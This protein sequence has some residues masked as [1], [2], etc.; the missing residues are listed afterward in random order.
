M[1]RDEPPIVDTDWIADSI[2]EECK[3]SGSCSSDQDIGTPLWPHA[4]LDA[5][6]SEAL[7]RSQ[8]QIVVGLDRAGRVRWA[9]EGFARL[10]GVS[11]EQVAGLSL[12][13]CL[14]SWS[15]S[16]DALRTQGHGAHR[17]LVRLLAHDGRERVFDLE[18]LRRDAAD[19]SGGYVLTALDV[20]DRELE[21]ARERSMLDAMAEGL[22]ILNA[23]GEVTRCNAAAERILGLPAQQIL[24]RTPRDPSWRAVTLEGKDFPGD[25]HPAS[26]TLRTG[27]AVHGVVHGV[28]TP[29]GDLKWI[30]VSAEPIRDLG[31]A[32]IAVV[33]TMTDVTLLQQQA[34]EL[35]AQRTELAARNE[36]IEREK[37]HLET[38]LDSPSTGYWD[39][40]I[41]ADTLVLS[42]SWLAM[43]GYAPGELPSKPE[44]WQDLIH[45]ADL[46]TALE[47]M[48]EHFDS[49][50]NVPYFVR[51]RYRHKQGQTVWVLCL[52]RVVEWSA[53]G[54]PERMVGCHIDVSE[55]QLA[56]ERL[57][58]KRSELRL[59]L[60]AI[61][62]VVFYKDAENRI[63]DLNRQAADSIGRPVEDIVG[64]PTERFFPAAE[65]AA[66]LR[67]DHEVL[68]SGEPKLGIIEPYTTGSGEQRLVRTDK[69]PL[70]GVSGDFD[71]LVAIVTDITDVTRVQNS[72][73]KAESRL[74]MAMKTAEIGLWDLDLTSGQ[75]YL[76]DTFF[77]MLGY[78]PDEL[79]MTLE[80]VGRLCHPDGRRR[81]LARLQRHYKGE[82]PSWSSEHRMLCKS[83]S[84]C[85][86]RANG[87]VVEHGTDGEPLRV[88]GC[89]VNIGEL[90]EINQR[91]ELAN[92]SSGAWLW[93]WDLQDGLIR[94]EAGLHRVLGEAPS[95]GPVTG[96]YFLDR[97]HPEDRQGFLDAARRMRHVDGRYDHSCRFRCADGTYRWLRAVGMVADSAPDG[98]PRRLI[99]Q[100]TDITE[101]VQRE[102]SLR[103]ARAKAEKV[104]DELRDTMAAL[105]EQT[106]V[107]W[108][109][110]KA[111]E[112][113][114]QAKSD[115]LANMSH[116]I[117]TPMNGI[118]GMT[119]LLLDT[120]LNVEQSRFAQIVRSS[121]ESLLALINDI[122]DFSKIEA[123]RLEMEIVEFDVRQLL[124]DVLAMFASS[125]EGKG[126]VLVG[127]VTADVP[128]VVCS[129]PG[130]LRQILVNLIGNAIKFTHRGEVEVTI[131]VD[132]EAADT[133]RLACAVRDTGIGIPQDKQGRIFD[134][135][136]QV[137]ASTTREFGGT[138][139]GL[140]I[141]K[142][143]LDLM[144]G[145]ISVVSEAGLGSTFQF[146]L[147]VT[148]PEG[149]LADQPQLSK[150]EMGRKVL[151]VDAHPDR[152]RSMLA[153]LQGWGLEG[154]V[155]E[156]VARLQAGA[157]AGDFKRGCDLLI[158]GPDT[159]RGPSS[160]DTLRKLHAQSSVA[161]IEVVPFSSVE[162]TNESGVL[163]WRRINEPVRYH[164][165]W[166]AV[167]ELL[168]G[169]GKAGSAGGPA[170]CRVQSR[171]NLRRGRILLAEDNLTNQLVAKGML[172]KF[173]LAVD[174]VNNGAEAIR[175][176]EQTSY[177]LVFM[178]VQMPEVDGLEATVR[179]REGS[180]GARDP[181]VRIIALT[182]HALRG[183]RERCLGAG[184][185]DYLSKPV[186][187]EGFEAM[188][189][190]WLPADEPLDLAP[191]SGAVKVF[192]LAGLRARVLDDEDLAQLIVRTFLAETPRLIAQLIKGA[193]ASDFERV[194]ARSHDV[195]SAAANIGGETLRSAVSHL[196]AAARRKDTSA[197]NDAA[198]S[199]EPIFESLRAA[200]VA[201]L[202]EDGRAQPD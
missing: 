180:T 48:R 136:S 51:A 88:M 112:A 90:K 15:G 191:D 59:I 43:L 198:Q 155:L 44:T 2:Q 61:P 119:D 192:D 184:M 99:G 104:N 173:G 75:L 106:R 58:R 109:M 182:A 196:E 166:G 148:E 24:G 34:H 7:A 79:P 144:G 21:R 92:A 163:R 202:D 84:W 30:A 199:I 137:D 175:A 122:L 102:H 130:R 174:T 33:A 52:G 181:S 14:P 169:D 39:W 125:C 114:D 171:R 188:L 56:L 1:S 189:D 133:V 177:D 195:R 117:R 40:D 72:L 151:I 152:A 22:V 37:R 153:T 107:A 86:V 145:K 26:V 65:A 60:D 140:A 6:D 98:S 176:L 200:L 100:H 13:A 101:Q 103:E 161:I 115:F 63:L 160:R 135:F 47:T 41:R 54:Q 87:E 10:V 29:A 197:V 118:I 129:D 78:S 11:I 179:I 187:P 85:W 124:D 4:A 143:L 121:G 150:A 16:L 8:A 42:A 28:H 194:A 168:Q 32:L 71:A 46:A 36:S 142:R 38:I 9:N 23:E 49:R 157:S 134:S 62:A 146:L 120:G 69:I 97:V 183:D 95:K 20:T 167:R 80:T 170:M 74:S 185:D 156:D 18:M 147:P 31:G 5:A 45:P 123:G 172:G 89:H 164:D 105:E 186:T 67:D 178:D 53:A 91:F 126:I 138:G 149:T 12:D 113:A 162:A 17:A 19:G 128:V 81:A 110:A 3:A 73:A 201:Y 111:A 64:Q 141:C 127:R 132:L 82:E 108:E 158:L 35:A 55:G 116:E 57:G 77:T 70:K 27:E 131:G 139:L 193:Q 96:D 50:G 190:K 165:L 94:T 76:S 66:Y 159:D 83:G 93:E 25:E 154:E 68:R